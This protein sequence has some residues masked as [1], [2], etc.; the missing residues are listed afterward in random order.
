MLANAAPS[1]AQEDVLN[2]AKDHLEERWNQ[3]D[4]DE[5]KARTALASSYM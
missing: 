5:M 3:M 4:I 1:F 2:P